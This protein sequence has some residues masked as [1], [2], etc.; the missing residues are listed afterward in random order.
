[1]RRGESTLPYDYEGAPNALHSFSPYGF[2]CVSSFSL[3]VSSAF[4][5]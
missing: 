5:R 2:S 1:M 4:S 3:A